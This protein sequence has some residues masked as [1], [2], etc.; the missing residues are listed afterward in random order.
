MLEFGIIFWVTMTMGKTQS[1]VPVCASCGSWYGNE[2]HMGGTTV[3]N[4]P[5]L[6]D[7]IHRREFVELGK[8]L[9]RNAAIPSTE[10]YIKRCKRCGRGE[11][12]IVVQRALRG[13]TGKLQ[14][15]NVTNLTLQPNESSLLLKNVT[16]D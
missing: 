2:E 4:E 1:Q 8:L 15:M 7:L 3:L 14:M 6:L 12:F 5:L 9:E 11:S 13:Q 16:V 10:L